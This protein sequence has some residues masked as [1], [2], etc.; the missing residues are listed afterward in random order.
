MARRSIDPAVKTAVLEALKNPE[1]NK[2]ELAKQYGLSLPTL[3]NWL[4][5]A[6]PV[7]AVP[8]TPAE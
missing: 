4:K 2:V 5:A 1:V 3:Y 7:E 6:R 8:E